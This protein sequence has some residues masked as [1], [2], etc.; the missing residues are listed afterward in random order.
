MPELFAVIRTRGPKWNA[1]LPL[2]QQEDW[3]GHADFMNGLHEDGF[4]LLGG[5]LQ[6]TP[7]VLLITR[8]QSAEEIRARL[9]ADCWTQNDLLRVK[10]IVPWNLR[11]GSLA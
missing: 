9:Q 11:L 7:D 2:E 6:G 1:A 10:E 8:A 3:R 4:V 5:P